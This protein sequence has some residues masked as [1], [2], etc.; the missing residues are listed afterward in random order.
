MSLLE[1]ARNQHSNDRIRL[2]KQLRKDSAQKVA[3]AANWELSKP[4]D[5]LSET[6]LS[7][8]LLLG[9]NLLNVDYD[10]ALL[11]ERWFE[12]RWAH[13]RSAGVS[14]NTE[15]ISL[16]FGLSSQDEINAAVRELEAFLPFI[17]EIDDDC[18]PALGPVKCV[19]IDHVAPQQGLYRLYVTA[20]KF[21]IVCV[22]IGVPFTEIQETFGT[23][24]ECVEY[25]ARHLP[26]QTQS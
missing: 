17:T 8:E 9:M 23:A 6:D 11:C 3:E 15:Q 21:L 18:L 13:I 5:D 22:G 24:A 10:F 20:S 26:R 25:I 1:L 16:R 2:L 12:N 19:S 14:L 7:P 4:W